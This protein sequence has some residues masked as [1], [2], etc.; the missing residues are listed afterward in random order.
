MKGKKIINIVLNVVIW[1]III[2]AT[3]LTI[4][5]LNSRHDGVPRIF[6]YIPL[7]V[8]SESMEPEI[9]KGDLIVN[10]EYNPNTMELNN[11]ILVA[12]FTKS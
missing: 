5:T 6:G 8:Q 11:T 1:I 4:S 3:L 9:M 7:N 2:I 12:L 10:K